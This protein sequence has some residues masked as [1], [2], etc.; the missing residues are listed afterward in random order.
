MLPVFV[1]L[2]HGKQFDL[3]LR[4]GRVLRELSGFGPVTLNDKDQLYQVY[5]PLDR[6]TGNK[7]NDNDDE[8]S[9]DMVVSSCIPGGL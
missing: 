3:Y 9:S 7:D 4:V 2:G 5:D 8:D 1:F 6:V